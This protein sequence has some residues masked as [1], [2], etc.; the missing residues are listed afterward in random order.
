MYRQSEKN[1]VKQQYLLHMSSQYG[2]LRLTSGWDLL[3][4][5]VHPPNFNRFRILASLLQRRRS[6]EANQTL[7]DVWPSPGLLHYIYTFDCSC[8]LT[9][10]RHV[11]NSLCV[12]VL[13]SPI[14]AALLHGTPAAGSA[15][16]CGMVVKKRPVY[17]GIQGMKLR[18]FRRGRH[19]DE[20]PSRWASA[21]ILVVLLV[22]S[23]M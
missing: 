14:L 21:H 4:S 19:S 15:K 6:P 16:L 13:R 23:S 2:E 5:L 18:N 17:C 22:S 7:H 3:A 9:E 12:Q 20:R 1:L 10:F 11:Q 8:A